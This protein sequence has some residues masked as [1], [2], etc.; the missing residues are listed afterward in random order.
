MKK[1]KTEKLTKKE[2]SLLK[3]INELETITL[4]GRHEDDD[5]TYTICP[6]HVDAK[7][8]KKAWKKEGWSP[9]DTDQNEL[10]YEYWIEGKKGWKRSA[11]GVKGA[12]PVTVRGW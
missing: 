8:F 5:P 6:G 10:S 1:N 9:S 2:K 4:G 7:T 3:E 12:V 11:P